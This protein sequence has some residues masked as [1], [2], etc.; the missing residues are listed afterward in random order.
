F[1]AMQDAQDGALQLELSA[2][3]QSESAPERQP[4]PRKKLDLLAVPDH[5]PE[6]TVP[7]RPFVPKRIREEAEP[8]QL[9]MF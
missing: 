1:Q 8:V 5:A 2:Q 6:A 4:K 7:K 3:L 9:A